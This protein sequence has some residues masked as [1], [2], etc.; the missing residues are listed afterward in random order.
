LPERSIPALTGRSIHCILFDL[1]DTLWSRSDA[2]A[3]QRLETTANLRAVALL[4]QYVA[5]QSLPALDDVALGQQLRDALHE[6][7]G[8]IIRR[9]PKIEPNGPLTVL[10]V[11]TQWGIEGLDNATGAAIFEALRIHIHGSRQIFDDVYSTLAALQE[12]G[13]LLGIVSNRIWGGSPFLEDLQILGLLKYFD[14]E[15]IAI[16][17]DLGVRKPDPAIFLHVLN[18]L[19]LE[20][21]HVVMVGD[22]LLADI[23]GAQKLGIFAI[24]KPKPGQRE[25]VNAHLIAQNA[26]TAATIGT[27]PVHQVH[28]FSGLSTGDRPADL[29][30]GMHVTDDDYVL[31]KM[32]SHDG[33]LAPFMRGEI[34]PDLIIEHLSELLDI[35]TKAGE[36]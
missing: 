5:P 16:S 22:S 27:H 7:V 33:K 18:A 1:G 3:W 2:P 10:Q 34:K 17:G 8:T 14:P 29:P 25:L 26:P 23:L 31:A 13:F 24:W 20:P 6:Q 28:H 32:R 11:L 36:Q 4:R 19:N 12:R 15:H 30:P 35:F 21:E 9:D